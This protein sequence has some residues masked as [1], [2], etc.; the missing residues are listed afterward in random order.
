MMKNQFVPNLSTGIIE[1]CKMLF[2][3]SS[4]IE[5]VVAITKAGKKTELSSERPGIDLFIRYW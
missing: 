1:T 4:K 2:S 5:P 3:I